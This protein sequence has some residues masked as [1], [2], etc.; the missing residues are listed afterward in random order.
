MNSFCFF[1]PKLKYYCI[2]NR[3]YLTNRLPHV[4][5]AEIDN[6]DHDSMLHNQSEEGNLS[7]FDIKVKTV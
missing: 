1:L 6:I 4:S 2:L 5:I 3:F 7:I